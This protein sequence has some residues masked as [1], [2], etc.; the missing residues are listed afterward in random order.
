MKLRKAIVVTI[1]DWLKRD[2]ELGR[3]IWVV[4]TLMLV[5][6][7]PLV[8]AFRYFYEEPERLSEKK[9]S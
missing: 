3:G 6:A 1:E 4:G 9:P 8:I 5:P 2:P 7:L